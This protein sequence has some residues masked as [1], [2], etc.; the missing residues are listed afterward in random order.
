MS[1]VDK[2]KE[3]EPMPY[4]QIVHWRLPANCKQTPT[5]TE[6]YPKHSLKITAE[7][8]TYN[9]WWASSIPKTYIKPY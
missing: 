7:E 9:F 1:L 2:Y 3:N 5:N 4:A 6:K 8:S